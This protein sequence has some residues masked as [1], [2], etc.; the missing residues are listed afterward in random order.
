MNG[1]DAVDEFPC[2]NGF[3]DLIIDSK[4]SAMQRE[5]ETS[6]KQAEDKSRLPALEAA[7]TSILRELGENADRQGL[8]RT[9]LRAA[10]AMQFLTKGYH[11]TVDGESTG[12][13]LWALHWEMILSN[14]KTVINVIRPLLLAI[15]W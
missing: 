7:Y 6:R 3:S 1:Q 14:Y 5:H 2:N 13:S 15:K 8:L 12:P 9:P 11:E 4:K 10:K